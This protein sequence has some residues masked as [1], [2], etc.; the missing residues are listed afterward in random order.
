M[1]FRKILRILVLLCVLLLCS[2]TNDFKENN[3]GQEQITSDNVSVCKVEFN[4]TYKQVLEKQRKKILLGYTRYVGGPKLKIFDTNKNDYVLNVSNKFNKPFSNP[5]F[6]PDGKKVSALVNEIEQNE[7]LIIINIET[8]EIKYYEDIEIRL[9]SPYSWFKDNRRI[10]AVC[11]LPEHKTQVCI[12]DTK[13]SEVEYLDIITGLDAVLGEGII[14]LSSRPN[15][16]AG[17]KNIAFF[18]KESRQM[19]EPKLY[20]SDYNSNYDSIYDTDCYYFNL[21]SEMARPVIIND[22]LYVPK[23]EYK[24]GTS[25]ITD[26]ALYKYPGLGEEYSVIEVDH[27]LDLGSIKG[28]SS[29]SKSFV[30][31]SSID[32]NYDCYLED[33]EYSGAMTK[34]FFV[35]YINTQGRTDMYPI[36]VLYL[37]PP[38]KQFIKHLEEHKMPKPGDMVQFIYAE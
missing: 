13:T 3:T 23:Y 30:T 22:D 31:F 20:I 1:K 27:N 7:T 37:T 18:A 34:Y 32:Y 10:L 24:R 6:S 29:K 11:K 5:Q 2:C 26:I 28:Y 19:Y 9:S 38:G 21:A 33:G 35:T 8:S 14:G 4:S 12:I 36:G 16:F 25:Q 17:D 15:M